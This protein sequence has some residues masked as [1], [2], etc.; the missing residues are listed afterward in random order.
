MNRYT[1]Y[2]TILII[3]LGTWLLATPLLAQIINDAVTWKAVLEDKGT[4]QKTL[5]LTATTKQGWHFYD[6]NMPADGP[7]SLVFK[8]HKLSGARALGDFIPSRPAHEEYDS[9]F[10][11]NL[12][13]Y[14]GTVTFKQKIE[15]TSYDAFHVELEVSSSACNTEGCLPPQSTE[16]AFSNKD[17][18]STAENK[19]ESGSTES[20]AEEDS[21]LREED[22]PATSATELASS[23][24]WQPMVEVLKAYGDESAR[25]GNS[26]LLMVFIYGFLGG[27]IALITPCV[28]PMIPMTVS[29]FL[30]RTKKR[31]EAIKD[32]LVYGLSIVVIYLALGIAVTLIFGASALNSLST[33]AFFNLLFFAILVVFAISFF[34]AFE[35]TMPS[36]W[37]NKLD[38]KADS[39]RGLLSIFF[40]AFTLT[41]VSF[42][43]TGPIVGT[44]LVQASTMSILGPAIG[45]L[46]F[47]IA[48]ALPFSLFA[49]FPN[50]L[51]NL[52][53][54]GGWL[55]SVKVVMA[56]L[57]LALSLKFLTVADMAYGWG[58]LSRETFLA[59]WI[60]IFALLGIYLLG[61]IRFPH[62]TPM[63]KI[64]VGRFFL[65]LVSLSFAIY[66]VP[67]LWGAP[68][69]AVCA[70]TPPLSTQDF[71]LYEGSVE[72]HFDDYEEGMKYAQRVNKPVL[73]DFSGWG[74]VNCRE[75]ESS[76]WVDPRVKKL[77]EEDYVLITLMVDDKADLPQVMEVDDAGTKRKLRTIGDKW[78][79]LQRHKFADNSQPFYVPLDLQ[80]V[81]LGPSYKR[82]LN[83]DKYIEFL[84][85]GLKEFKA[86]KAGKPTPGLQG[87]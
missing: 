71:N 65:A 56:F 81:P 78:S 1:R 51:Q 36:R 25:Q 38:S 49:V 35:F 53:K 83:V 46:G 21:L 86:R 58:L 68:L 48:L 31:R 75:M 61:K 15:V 37:T 82:N 80:G 3:F 63:E 60:A 85:N 10:G 41:L 13:W 27:F 23:D 30:K 62:D 40:M 18:K 12:R 34:G 55:N 20:G 42:S 26:S 6:Q 77:L 7:N 43:C 52:P 22:L 9:N 44:L 11:M 14:Q 8:Y 87:E 73:L 24:L 33:N 50:V 72:A 69:K 16:F 39:T 28:W 29:F 45:M 66:L 5:I 64:G 54:S 4:A 79:F 32:A 70:F 76:V 59:I 17:L 47:S 19:L 57:E 74:C 67:G 2:F 84:E